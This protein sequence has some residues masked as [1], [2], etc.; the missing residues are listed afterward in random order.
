MTW[1]ELRSWMMVLNFKP[2][3]TLRKLLELADLTR[4]RSDHLDLRSTPKRVVRKFY[5]GLRAWKVWKI[6]N[7]TYYTRFNQKAA[8]HRQGPSWPSKKK[9]G[10]KTIRTRK[11]KKLIKSGK[12]YRKRTVWEGCGPVQPNS[13]SAVREDCFKANGKNIY[14]LHLNCFIIIVRSLTIKL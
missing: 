7:G 3:G 2:R 9:L 1:R 4:I 13:N 5:S 8:R 11:A 10:M 14:R 12:N 6:S